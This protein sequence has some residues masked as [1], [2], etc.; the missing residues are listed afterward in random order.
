MLKYSTYQSIY[1][2]EMTET[3]RGGLMDRLPVLRVM[4]TRRLM[5]KLLLA[6]VIISA[7]CTGMV[8][9]FAGSP[10][11]DTQVEQVVVAQGDTLWEIALNHK[12]K[13]MD[14]RAYIRMIKE[15][16]HLKTSGIQAGDVLSLPIY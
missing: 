1:N 5:L 7:G 13:N 15:M 2:H 11:D 10:Q 14:T 12:P 3:G 6:V 4:L 8:R 9:V 16:N